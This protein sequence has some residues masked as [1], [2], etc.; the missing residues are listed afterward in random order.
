[1]GGELLASRP[2]CSCS[3]PAVLYTAAAYTIAVAATLGVSSHV[4][5]RISAEKMRRPRG[6]GPRGA[7]P[8]ALR[9]LF[10]DC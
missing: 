6:A 2:N 10:R 8:P 1:M 4:G 3:L 5:P 7:L 9:Q